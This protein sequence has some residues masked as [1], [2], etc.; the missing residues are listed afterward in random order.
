MCRGRGGK[1]PRKSLS[2][3][4][5]ASGFL[6]GCW[7]PQRQLQQTVV[8][9]GGL[10]TLV[11]LRKRGHNAAILRSTD[12]PFGASA[13]ASQHLDVLHGRDFRAI[14][15]EDDHSDVVCQML[16]VHPPL[17]RLDR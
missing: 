1:T 3:H 15:D 11:N 13:S 5:I 14:K 2:R 9:M 8:T 17:R 12:Q 10:D 16:V 6:Q 4:P 7:T